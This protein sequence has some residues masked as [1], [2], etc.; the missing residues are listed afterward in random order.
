MSFGVFL[1]LKL[2]KTI[3][4]FGIS[5]LEFAG[6]QKILQIKKNKKQKTKQNKIK[7]GTKN[8]L[9]GYFGL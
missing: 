9:F 3:V 1:D 4:I 6:M 8:A 2:E 7:F 5:T